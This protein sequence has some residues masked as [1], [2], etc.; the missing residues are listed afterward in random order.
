[1]GVGSSTWDSRSRS[2]AFAHKKGKAE[3]EGVRFSTSN[4]NT[5]TENCVEQCV[6]SCT[7]C[8]LAHWWTSC[9]SRS[10]L[11]SSQLVLDESLCRCACA[12]I[13]RQGKP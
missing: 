13:P 9:S 6:A 11:C 4:L 10:A 7:R 8:I 12:S 1:M 5:Q 3:A 2:Y